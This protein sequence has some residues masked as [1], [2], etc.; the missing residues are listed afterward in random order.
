MYDVNITR[1]SAC[2]DIFA[3]PLVN[4]GS[5]VECSWQHKQVVMNFSASRV[6]A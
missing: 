1:L 5:V 6:L 3:S 4:P 2:L